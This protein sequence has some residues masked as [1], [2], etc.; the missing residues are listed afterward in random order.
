MP[1]QVVNLAKTAC[2]MSPKPSQLVVLPTY[3]RNAG[4]QP[5]ANIQDHVPI[6]NIVPFGPCSSPT[7]PP[8][9]AATTTAGGVLTPVHLSLDRS[10]LAGSCMGMS[11]RVFTSRKR[12]HDGAG[13]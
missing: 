9:A 11:S 6:V 1:L 12:D 5:A 10:R 2:S 4:G 8:T 7:F 3:R 13:R